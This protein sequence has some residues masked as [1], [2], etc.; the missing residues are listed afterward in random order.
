MP[1]GTED[2]GEMS[3][4][5]CPTDCTFW[6]LCFCDLNLAASR[7]FSE[8]RALSRNFLVALRSLSSLSSLLAP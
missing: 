2:A 5:A 1:M 3:S 7:V 8:G 6:F 4:V